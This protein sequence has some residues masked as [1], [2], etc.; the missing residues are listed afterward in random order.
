MKLLFV[1]EGLNASSIVAQPWKHVIE[2][3]R[4]IRQSGSSVEIV[5]S[6]SDENQVDTEILGVPILQV[7]KNKLFMN[8][9]SLAETVN[10]ADVDLVNWHC[11]DIWASVYFWRLRKQLKTNVV[12]TLHSGILS[13]EDLKNLSALDLLQLREFWNNF[14]NAAVP[15]FLVRK[16]TSAHFLK[17]TI[18]L[19]KRTASKLEKYGL[20][21]ESVTSIPSGVDTNAFVP[22]KGTVDESLILYFGPL[23]PF[24]GADVL[25]SAFRRVRKTLPKTRLMLL[26][27]DSQHKGYWHRKTENVENVEIVS[28]TLDQK[29]LVE[30]LSSA[31]V[32][33]LPFRFWPQVECP[34][35]ILESM[36][37]GKV[38][39]TTRMGAIPEIISNWENGVLVHP[40]DSKK[41]ADV[42]VELLKD[43]LR[44]EEV[45][46]KARDYVERFHDWK[47]I[48][49]D[50]FDVLSES[51]N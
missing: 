49:K 9:R 26:A 18:T 6:K 36:A 34:L 38:V 29:G 22:S 45:G 31:S 25:I 24:R 20:Q 4:I 21:K 39:V 23:S 5:T 2:V 42:L 33:A 48:A 13:Y 15:K 43:P 8:V 46:R 11:S 47:K 19:S 35:T 37:A 41:L 44:R 16:W 51:V 40:K 7:E 3:A 10:Q 28:G 27:R 32:V 1:C 50:T 30:H 14:L 17:H 12:W